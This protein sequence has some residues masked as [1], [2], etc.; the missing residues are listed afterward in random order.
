MLGGG[1]NVTPPF[2][3]MPYTIDMWSIKPYIDPPEGEALPLY[4]L[5]QLLI[6][7]IQRYTFIDFQSCKSIN[8]SNVAKDTVLHFS[9]WG[10]TKQLPAN[11]TDVEVHMSSEL[12]SDSL[13]RDACCL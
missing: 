3:P 2:V 11:W 1:T 4:L 8:F 9:S 7:R 12:A 6:P 10:D 5:G 13:N